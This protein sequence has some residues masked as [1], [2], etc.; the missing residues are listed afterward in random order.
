MSVAVTPSPPKGPGVGSGD[1]TDESLSGKQWRRLAISVY[2]P[3]TLSFIGFGAVTPLIALT[4]HDLGATTAQ[5]A[6]VVALLGIGGLLGAL[7]AGALTQR[8]GERRAIVGSLILDAACMAVAGFA[9][10]LWVLAAAVLVMGLSGAVLII[11]RQSFLT[12]FI[13]FRFR[14]RALSTLGGVF[15]VGALL[16]PLAGA[17][18]VTVFDLRAAYWLAI[19][20]SLAA[21]ATSALLPDLPEPEHHDS[22]EPTRMASVLRAHTRTLLTVGIGAAALMLVRA[23]RDALL[24]LWAAE[25]GLGPAETSL[26]FAASSAIDLTL[27]YLGGSMMD[28]LGRRAVAVPAM[29]IMGAAFGLLPLTATAAGLTAIALGLGVG[30]GISSGIVLTLGSDASPA[31]GRHQFL[32]GWRLVT[33][34]GQAAGPL[35]V[36]GLAAVAS[37]SAAALTVGAI[38]LLGGAWLWYWVGPPPR[39]E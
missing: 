21:A 9:T 34:L 28:R 33:G 2:L 12:E 6:F 1:V 15:R 7:P 19:I 38:G 5:A 10:H 11:G 31:V 35:L 39:R 3:T 24:P 26:I 27:F 29:V 32:A 16:G 4:A 23:T 37:L 18:V 20:T 13:P 22:G 30:N 25:I 17:A 8:V 14:A 36:S